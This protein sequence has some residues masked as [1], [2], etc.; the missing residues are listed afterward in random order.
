[1][2]ARVLVIA[3]TDSSGGAGLAA[4][5]AALQGQGVDVRLAVTAVTAQ[6]PE[7]LVGTWPV[8]AVA[9]AAQ[10]DLAGPVQAVKIGMLGSLAVAAQVAAWLARRSL[11]VVID[12]VLGASAGG[13]LGSPAALAPLLALATLVT[14]NLPELEALGGVAWLSRHPGAVLVKGGHGHGDALED[15]LFG[16]GPA[17]VWRHPRLP[18]VHRGTGCRLASAIAARLALGDP[19]PQAVDTG[20]RWLQVALDAA[21]AAG[22][23]SPD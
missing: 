20:I 17:Q 12:P 5:L 18:G 3:G 10:L 11:P 6:G 19:L 22:R 4:D 1:M 23:N 16:A 9:L 15:H 8:P 2:T 7:G 13:A 14:P 21:A